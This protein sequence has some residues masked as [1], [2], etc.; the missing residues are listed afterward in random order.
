MKKVSEVINS[1]IPGAYLRFGDGEINALNGIG[2]IEQIGDDKMAKEMDEAISLSGPGIIKSLMI[3]SKKFG[4]V[5]GMKDGFHLSKDNWAIDQL[6]LCYKYFIGDY[7]YSHAAL[8]YTLIYQREIA[9]KFFKQLKSIGKIMFVGNEKIDDNLLKKIF[10]N[11]CIH[12]KTIPRDAFKQIDN[13]EKELNN[14]LKKRGNYTIVAFAVG[15]SSK[16]LQKRLFKNSLNI[17][18]F[19]IGS[20]IDALSGAE[21]RAW[22][23]PSETSKEYYKKFITEI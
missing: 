5:P 16:I 20:V 1:K 8:S 12:I 13:I 9:L 19:D 23:D 6:N 2:A 4:M 21:T 18:T 14:E 10:G 11:D 17:F 22:I 7:I 15:P 3:H